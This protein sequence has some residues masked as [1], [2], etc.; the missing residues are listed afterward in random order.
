MLAKL[1]RI[2]ECEEQAAKLTMEAEALKMEVEDEYGK[3]YD[4]L[5]RDLRRMLAPA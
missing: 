2:K 4:E 3:A 1:E 5:M